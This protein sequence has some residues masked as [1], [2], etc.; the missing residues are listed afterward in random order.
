MSNAKKKRGGWDEKKL[1]WPY[2]QARTLL[3]RDMKWNVLMRKIPREAAAYLRDQK[4]K[5]ERENANTW[6][7]LK[8]MEAGMCM[9]NR[10]GAN[11]PVE[12]LHARQVRERGD[13]PVAFLRHWCRGI[14]NLEGRVIAAAGRLEKNGDIL[15]PWANKMLERSMGQVAS[16]KLDE[17]V[18]INPAEEVSVV[19]EMRPNEEDARYHVNLEKRTCGCTHWQ[20]VG[21]ACKHA[22]AVWEMYQIQLGGNH[23]ANGEEQ[24]AYDVRRA[25]WAVNHKPWFLAADFIAAANVLKGNRIKLPCD[26]IMQSDPTKYPPVP[27]A[28]KKREASSAAHGRRRWRTAM[29]HVGLLVTT[30]KRVITTRV[31]SIGI[32]PLMVH[33]KMPFKT[34]LD[35]LM[36]LRASIERF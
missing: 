11:N 31:G 7:A 2:Q 4:D 16:V 33:F 36:T 30:V 22:V 17:G 19:E 21:I 5:E 32:T 23:E 10:C 29:R 25:K 3:A 12:Q 6:T 34:A 14:T 24:E 27:I 18:I 15:T 8:H 13:N 9:F 1:F 35:A 26:S 20:S 28:D